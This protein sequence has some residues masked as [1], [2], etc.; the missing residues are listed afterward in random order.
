METKHTLSLIALS[1]ALFIGISLSTALAD[2]LMDR[3]GATLKVLVDGAE[4]KGNSE[5]KIVDVAGTNAYSTYWTSAAGKSPRCFKVEPLDTRLGA[6]E[7]INI[8]I[9]EIRADRPFQQWKDYKVIP[10]P[11][12]TQ[13][14]SGE[15]FCPQEFILTE[16]LRYKSLPPGDYVVRVGYWGV[17]NWDRQDILLSVLP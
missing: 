6:G 12:P 15:G 2:P 5:H 4:T 17:G 11:V 1:A 3:T 7:R 9:H 8:L 14:S 10:D 16:R 13:F